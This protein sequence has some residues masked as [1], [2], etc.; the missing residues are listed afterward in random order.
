[1]ALFCVTRA[2]IVSFFSPVFSSTD[3]FLVLGFL[4]VESGWCFFFFPHS[5]ARYPGVF[6]PRP[7][8]F[9]LFLTLFGPLY[10]EN[11]LFSSP[12]LKS[13]QEMIERIPLLL[14]SYSFVPPSSCFNFDFDRQDC[15]FCCPLLSPRD[16][17]LHKFC[18]RRSEAV[19]CVPRYALSS[20][21]RP[22]RSRLLRRVLPHCSFA[23]SSFFRTICASRYGSQTF[24]PKNWS[25]LAQALPLP[26]SDI[27]ARDPHVSVAS[28]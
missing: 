28:P 2:L 21:P 7:R 9:F 10:E 23:A 24:F 8:G 15:S 26:S 17:P 6:T 13:R 11:G 12:P 18:S 1:V 4:F 14:S 20:F 22:T 19:S 5:V 27:A 3:C 25:P 16:F